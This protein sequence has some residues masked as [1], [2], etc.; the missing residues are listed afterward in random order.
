MYFLHL[1]LKPMKKSLLLFLMALVGVTAWAGPGTTSNFIRVDQFGYRPNASKVAVIV[2]PQTGYDGNQAFSP[3]LGV[4]QYQVRKWDDNSVVFSGTLSA[5]NGGAVD[6]SSG[7]KAWWFDFSS[8]TTAGSYYVY[9]VGRQVGSY[10]FEIGEEVYNN[11]L[12]SAVRMFFYNRTGIAKSA[13]HAGANWAD[14]ASLVGP[15]QDTQARSVDDRTNAA[16]AKDLSGGWWDAG[17]FNKY[18]TFTRSTMHSLLDAYEQKPNIWGDNYNIPESG[19]GLPDLVDEMKWELEWLKKMQ[20]SDGSSLSKLGFL[21]TVDGPRVG[22]PSTDTRPRYYYPGSCTSATIT[23]A[24]VF[25]HAALVLQT[26]PSQAAYAA[27]LRSRAIR[28]FNAY[29][30]APTKDTN[31]DNGTIA[32][33]DADV[34]SEKEENYVAKS[35]AFQEKVKLQAAV[36][37]FAL[38]GESS[39]KSWVDNNYLIEEINGEGGYSYWGPYLWDITDALLYYTKLPNASTGVV[40]DIRTRKISAARQ[41]FYRFDDNADPYRA[42]MEDYMYHW[43]SNLVKSTLSSIAYDMVIY[44]LDGSNK[45]NYKKRGEEIMHYLHGVNPQN[46]VYLSNMSRYGAERS[47]NE[48]Y[49]Y[50]FADGSD[51]DNPGSSKGGPPPG[52]LPGGPNQD[53]LKYNPELTCA[54]S[55]P[56]NQPKQKTYRDWN[57]NYPENSW[58]ITEPAIYYN[59]IYVKA[60]SR[61]VN[62]ANSSDNAYV[63]TPGNTPNITARYEAE[64]ATLTG[65][66]VAT[67]NAG[68]SGTGYADG[69][70]A[71]GDKIT[72]NINAA[73]AGG[74]TLKIRYSACNNQQNFVKVNG[75]NVGGSTAFSGSS[76]GTWLEKTL[77]V[78]LNAGS[79]TIVIEKDWGYM[80]VDYIE[81]TPP[82]ATT[83]YEAEKAVL[84]GTQVGTYYSGYSGTGYV[85]GLDATGDKITF[86]VNVAAVGGYTL[87]IRYTVCNDQ[88]NFVKVNGANAGGSSTVFPGAACGTGWLEKTLTVSLNTGLNTI[89]IEKDWGYMPVDYIEILPLPLVTTRYEAENATLTGTQVATYHSGYSGT[90]YVDGL[91]A[92]GDKISFTVNANLSNSYILKIRYYVCNE[93][94]NFVKVNGFDAEG[95][96][97]VF[98]GNSCGAWTDKEMTINLN[99]GS[100]TISIEKDFGFIGVDYIEIMNSNPSARIAS[101]EKA[102]LAL[103]LYPNP[104]T[105]DVLHIA[106]P[107]KQKGSV[108]LVD[109]FGKILLQ[110]PLKEQDTALR[111]PKGLTSGLYLVKIVVGN[112]IEVRKLVI[113]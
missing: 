39:Y 33:G 63:G 108:Y 43:G 78:S 90:G 49:H 6:A 74:Y 59:A 94:K 2:D 71:A 21:K 103:H 61:F 8:L 17:D 46:M 25:A 81:L 55:P 44:N 92:A 41:S 53:Y 57:T 15:N 27:D 12:R 4:N 96:S 32:S 23:L 50:W 113:K 45:A 47:A 19:N 109:T 64:N 35:L 65:T 85:D 62:S 67:S 89:V 111:M 58:E 56:C 54:L 28:A 82:P 83:R 10:R 88:R 107:Q 104:L 79:N 3:S 42:K 18:V 69:L 97:S 101:A 29:N 105:G 7:D 31:C 86:S 100:N 110:A 73:T 84:T 24:S 70:D 95:A 1:K 30:A 13:T 40:G 20:L 26:I 14:A 48:I 34:I 52:Y 80:P 93:Q 60:L 77:V 68:Y 9:D 76:C 99:A 102:P 36:Y 112:K 16:T 51:W 72:F 91:D 22:L 11:V 106:L 38:T 37:L 66:Q 5:W 75:A 98:P 87:K